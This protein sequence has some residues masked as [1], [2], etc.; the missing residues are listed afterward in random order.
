MTHTLGALAA[1]AKLILGLHARQA[2]RH[3][4]QRCKLMP[5]PFVQGAAGTPTREE[6]G[7]GVSQQTSAASRHLENI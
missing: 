3:A 2:A 5:A 1:K 7:K 4:R 6:G